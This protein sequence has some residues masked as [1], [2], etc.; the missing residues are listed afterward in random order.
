[1]LALGWVWETYHDLAL[2]YV[3]ELRLRLHPV[4]L[5]LCATFKLSNLAPDYAALQSNSR[6]QL[7]AV[8][9]D[10]SAHRLDAP[11]GH[12]CH[13]LIRPYVSGVLVLPPPFYSSFLFFNRIESPG[14][15]V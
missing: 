2:G 9:H 8:A 11:F 13:L 6:H 14:L 3:V 5:G 7:K 15:C 12:P 1:M 4:L 10:Q